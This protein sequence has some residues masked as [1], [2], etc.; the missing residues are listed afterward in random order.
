MQAHIRNARALAAGEYDFTGDKGERYRFLD[1]YDKDA[2]RI[3]RISLGKDCVCP[4]IP[5]EGASVDV[6]VE[7]LTNEKIVRGEDRDRSIGT[8]KLRAVN[9]E[10]AQK[11]A[12]K[13]AA[14]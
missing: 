14:A 5:D 1:L 7:L 11:G 13:A 6:W 12:L 2:G 9:V 3:V 4:A 10:L 8:L